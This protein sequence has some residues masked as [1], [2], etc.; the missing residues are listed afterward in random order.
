MDGIGDACECIEPDACDDN[1]PCTDDTCDV[2][3]GCVN[4]NNTAAC[5]DGDVCTNTICS[6]GECT[7]EATVEGCCNEDADCDITSACDTDNNVCQAVSCQLC[8]T[9]DSCGAGNACIDLTSGSYCVVSCTE[10]ADVCPAGTVCEPVGDG[11]TE[12]YCVPEKGDCECVV[13]DAVAC[14][15]GSLYTLDSC[16]ALAD[17]V[18]D[19]DGNGC[20]AGACLE[21]GTDATDTT[22]GADATDTTDGADATD[23]TDGADATDTTDGADATDAADTTDGADA[24][25]TTDGADGD[26]ATLAPSSSDSG[27]AT[28][29]NA[30]HGPMYPPLALLLVALAVIRIRRKQPAVL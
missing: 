12:L 20:E 3:T 25:D 26:T 24:A 17:E 8:E 30:E 15:N 28:A 11:E 14:D 29:G 5:D 2:E 21:P 1:N 27:C 7:V 22:D 13:T 16:G 10:Q 6:D 4:T 9:D 23:T 19:C 18:S